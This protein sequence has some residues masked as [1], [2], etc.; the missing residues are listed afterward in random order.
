[1]VAASAYFY[2]LFSSSRNPGV[3]LRASVHVCVLSS[4]FTYSA[5]RVAMPL[6]RC[7]MLSISRSVCSDCMRPSTTNAMSPT[8]RG[9]HR[10]KLRHFKSESN[11]WKPVWLLTPAKMPLFNNNIAIFR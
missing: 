10:A 5:V 7:I 11:R 8:L 9:R 2:R 3:V 4:N 6:I 1:M